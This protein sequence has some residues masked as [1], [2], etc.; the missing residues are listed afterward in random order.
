[1]A[2]SGAAPMTKE[3]LEF[4]DSLGITIYESYGLTEST[5]STTT[6]PTGGAR[7]GSVGKAI[8]GSRVEIDYGI[9]DSDAYEGEIVLYG[10]GV[11]EGYHNNQEATLQALD[12]DGCLRTGDLGYLDA[13]GYLYITGRSKDLYKLNSGRY[14][15]PAPLEEKPK[16]SPF[17]SHCMLYGAGQPYNVALIVADMP[18]LMGYF[19]AEN[20]T[21]A[22]VLAHPETR[23]LFEE[24]I[25]KYSR[26]FRAFELVRNFWLAA[27]PL[28]RANGMLTPA[29]KLRRR[30]VLRKYEAKLRSLY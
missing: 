7:F 17:I 26:D 4:F 6:N 11:M 2:F 13:D 12:K 5:G 14:V 25:L 19:R 29:L 1:M 21:P 20:L 15:A 30:N 22:Q 18:A 9:D 24:Q 10:P 8:P 28:T 27:E 3:V 16:L 23:R